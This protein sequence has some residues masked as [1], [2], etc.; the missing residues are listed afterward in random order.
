MAEGKN[1]VVA[2]ESA[3]DIEERTKLRSSDEYKN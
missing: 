2:A 3:G 1:I